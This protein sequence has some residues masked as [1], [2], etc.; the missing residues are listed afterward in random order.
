MGHFQ[1]EIAKFN[2]KKKKKVYLLL[3]NRNYAKTTGPKF[4]VKVYS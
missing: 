4:K 2:K 1:I 3:F